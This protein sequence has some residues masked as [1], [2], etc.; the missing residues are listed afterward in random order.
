MKNEI[1]QTGKIKNNIHQKK[2]IANGLNEVAQKKEKSATF[3]EFKEDN[4]GK[5]VRL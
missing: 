1:V 2:K 4:K 5:A 3:S